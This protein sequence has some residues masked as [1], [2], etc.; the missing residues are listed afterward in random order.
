MKLAPESARMRIMRSTRTPLGI[1]PPGLELN[2]EVVQEYK[3]KTT[4]AIE[5]GVQFDIP[6]MNALFFTGHAR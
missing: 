3:H 4:V 5:W 6:N 1:L 2:V